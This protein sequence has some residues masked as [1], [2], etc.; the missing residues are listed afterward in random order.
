MLID[1]LIESLGYNIIKYNGKEYLTSGANQFRALWTRDTFFSA[2][3]MNKIGL[4][5][6]IDNLIALCLK[7]ITNGCVPKVIDTMNTD[8]R[9]LKACMRHTIGLPNSPDSFEGNLVIVHEDSRT[10]CSIDSNVLLVLASFQT[11]KY[12]KNVSG[13]LDF[14][15]DKKDLSTGLILQEPY[16][17]WQ[18]SQ[19]RSGSTFLTNL[20]YYQAIRQYAEIGIIIKDGKGI[21]IDLEKLRTSMIKTFYNQATGLFKTGKYT[22]LADNLFAIKY[23]FVDQKKLYNNLKNSKLWKCKNGPGFTQTPN[24]KDVHV[25][26]KFGQLEN[27][28]NDLYWSWL[29]GFSGEIAFLMS[30]KE[31]GMKIYERLEKI[32]IRDGCIAEIYEK[33]G[34]KIFETSTYRA[35]CPFTWGT[36][37]VLGMCMAKKKEIK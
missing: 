22:C 11:G 37:F 21:P 7:N 4:G 28:H 23:G 27:Y 32:A 2:E 12:V 17:D 8:W 13:L 30:D 15:L 34:L 3:I 1:I 25:Q 26:V 29:M 24:C 19:D 14:Y 35:E 10:S 18:D 16:S 33:N 9:V 20:L 31:E 36:C 5:K 6:L